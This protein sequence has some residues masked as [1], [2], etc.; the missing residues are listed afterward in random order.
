[1]SCSCKNS[2]NCSN[3]PNDFVIYGTMFTSSTEYANPFL[4]GRYRIYF[5]GLK[6]LIYGTDW[7]Y[8]DDVNKTGGVKIIMAGYSVTPDTIFF[9]QFY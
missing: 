9:C 1:M 7:Q 2:S 8:I 4:T 3:C 6:W 5:Q